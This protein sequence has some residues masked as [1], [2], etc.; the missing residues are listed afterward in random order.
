MPVA[1]RRRDRGA[2]TTARPR[3]PCGSTE[4]ASPRTPLAAAAGPVRARGPFS[5]AVTGPSRSTPCS[6]SPKKKRDPWG[7]PVADAAD[8]VI[9]QAGMLV[10]AARCVE[11][12]G[13]EQSLLHAADGE[14]A[15]VRIEGEARADLARLTA[16]PAE[17]D[18]GLRRVEAEAQELSQHLAAAGLA[19]DPPA[20]T[21][22]Q[23]PNPHAIL[24]TLPPNSW[25][26]ESFDPDAL[27]AQL[28]S[29]PVRLSPDGP[30]MFLVQVSCGQTHYSLLKRYSEFRLM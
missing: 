18:D 29:P 2:S 9:E 8:M 4:L 27:R 24:Q 10:E 11:A 28:A 12:R 19:T 14:T 21:S 25:R 5:C 26:C 30:W 17:A 13:D 3:T 6:T 23:I 15:A 22:P 16:A 1:G 7:Y 20:R